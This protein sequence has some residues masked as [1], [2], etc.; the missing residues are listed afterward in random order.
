MK[1]PSIETARAE[2]V[3]NLDEVE[4]RLKSLRQ[5][6]PFEDALQ[7]LDGA[8]IRRCLIAIGTIKPASPGYDAKAPLEAPSPQPFRP[9]GAVLRKRLYDEKDK[10]KPLGTTAV[11]RVPPTLR[12]DIW[13]IRESLRLQA[14]DGAYADNDRKLIRQLRLLGDIHNEMLAAG[15]YPAG[16][17]STSSE[18]KNGV[19]AS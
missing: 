9:E 4:S 18:T 13:G 2:A 3:Y 6:A 10:R 12:Q 14:L 16:A 7:D 15:G 5:G 19:N 8:A 17:D 11:F 1:K